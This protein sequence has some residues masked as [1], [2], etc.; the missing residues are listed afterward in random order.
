MNTNALHIPYITQQ[1]S[2]QMALGK[3]G[4]TAKV[5]S[6]KQGRQYEGE[7]FR[8]NALTYNYTQ[9]GLD[10][11]SLQISTDIESFVP[12]FSKIECSTGHGYWRDDLYGDIY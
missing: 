7:G 3:P 11:L 2:Q 9:C 1:I 12:P 8:K 6:S 10:K 4:K 5:R